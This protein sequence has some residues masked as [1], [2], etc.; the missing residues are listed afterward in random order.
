M[1]NRNKILA[2]LLASSTVLI[3]TSINAA[4]TVNATASVTVQNAFE[5]VES[6]QL[7]FG[8]ITFAKGDG[9]PTTQPTILLSTQGESTA[10]NST[11]GTTAAKVST[12]TTGTPATFDIANASPFTTLNVT[13]SVATTDK[14]SNASAGSGN[15]KF[16]LKEFDFREAGESTDVE[17]VA[18]STTTSGSIATLLDGTS[19]FAVGATLE[20]DAEK[21][22]ID[23]V[24]SG[25]YT[26]KV[27]Y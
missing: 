10:T 21:D 25:S 4:E 17:G 22:Y 18:N 15:G 24:Y 16:S 14:L 27:S 20:A 19:S 7:S 5:L 26:V 12:I 11:G 13:I 9:T 2:A 23:G 1:L 8:T 6:E 3:T